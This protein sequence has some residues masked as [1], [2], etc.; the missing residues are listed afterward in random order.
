MGSGLEADCQ[1][2]FS[3]LQALIQNMFSRNIVITLL[4]NARTLLLIFSV[5]F[6]LMKVSCFV[7]ALLHHLIECPAFMDVLPLLNYGVKTWFDGLVP[8]FLPMKY[9]G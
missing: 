9:E 3:F 7:L 4:T 8:I 6:I 2:Y 5:V 1:T